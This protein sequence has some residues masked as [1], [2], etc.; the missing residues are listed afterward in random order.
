MDEAGAV[1][2]A[3]LQAR[4]TNKNREQ[5]RGKNIAWGRLSLWYMEF[6]P[7]NLDI[8]DRLSVRPDTSAGYARQ[9]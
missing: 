9:M 3:E 1:V 7:P 2:A 6:T 4:D 5:N 8:L